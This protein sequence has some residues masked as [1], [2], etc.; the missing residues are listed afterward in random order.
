MHLLT[1]SVC[2]RCR[3]SVFSTLPQE[4]WLQQVPRRHHS[5]SSGLPNFDDIFARLESSSRDGERRDSQPRSHDQRR[6][7]PLP[8]K[9]NPHSRSPFLRPT[10]GELPFS[11]PRNRQGRSSDG[12]TPRSPPPNRRIYQ[13]P[14]IDPRNAIEF[15]Q[16]DVQRW[17]S[18]P[19]VR[20]R[21]QDFG[22]PKHNIPALLT[23]FRKAVQS[24]Q[25][26]TPATVE[27]YHIDRF[28]QATPQTIA[29]QIDVI[30]N[31]VFYQWAADPQNEARLTGL[32][33][34]P[35]VVEGIQRLAQAADRSHPAEEYP[36]ARRMHRKV[37][38]HVGPTNSGKTHH[39][40]RALAASK[41]GVYAGPLRLLAHEI[42]E[43]LNLGEIIPLGVEE[44]PITPHT[45]KS[46]APRGNPLYAQ[47]CNMVT[48]EE[49][50]IV[51]QDAP[52]LSC[53]VE[54]LMLGK[55]YD[56]AVV[57]E[58][59]MIADDQRGYAWTS[60]VLG[61]C[62]EEVHLCG[63]ET[64]VPIVEALL[65]D[66]GDEL[67]VNRYERLT[68]LL[69]EKQSLAGDL[70]NVKPGDCI[71]TFSRSNIFGIKRQV[72]EKTG[73]RCAVVYGKLPPEIR[74]EQAA[75]FNDPNSGYDVLIGSDAIGMGLNLK[76]RR[77]IF[78]TVRK[79]DGGLDVP[80][81]VSQ[82][83]QIAGRAG[84][85][86]LNGSSDPAGYVTTLYPNDLSF[87]KATIAS[88]VSPLRQALL[89]YN[90]NTVTRIAGALPPESSL[91][92]IHQ[93][94][95]YASTL[96]P[97]YKYSDCRHQGS[98]NGIIAGIEEICKFVDQKGG[99]LPM[100]DRLQLLNAPVA[101]RVPTAIQVISDF[102]LQ[103]NRKVHVSLMSGLGK[104]TLLNKLEFIEDKMKIEKAAVHD[105]VKS[106]T[107]SRKMK[108][109]LS[110]VTSTDLWELEVLHGLIV[111]YLWMSF[112]NPVAYSDYEVVTS[113][114]ERTE[115]ALEWSLK[116][117]GYKGLK[118]EVGKNQQKMELMP[119]MGMEEEE[120]RIG[121]TN[122]TVA[123]RK[124]SIEYVSGRSKG[125]W[126]A[127]SPALLNRDQVDVESKR[128]VASAGLGGS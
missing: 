27:K 88:Q 103:Y 65:K 4:L 117:I 125:M 16:S 48:G 20:Q 56:V 122:R 22:I 61:L 32:V 66:T 124:G 99:N 8:S 108:A 26:S 101:W 113:L 96:D 53:T 44:K 43:R 21:L 111:F 87:V 23:A 73:M 126:S 106:N 80:L 46:I 59:Q 85:Y 35:S 6:R 92:T 98:K 67:I 89:G 3:Y 15:F 68:P 5:S 57:D 40:L 114:K 52:L 97:A 1:R 95:T 18:L 17:A 72:E 7:S 36:K 77:I 64:A 112:R 109:V 116:E 29:S 79:F 69:V 128:R 63:E 47:Q 100:R 70:S 38:M 54:M 105:D 58:I 110:Q 30:Y 91:Q 74:S 76:I 50:K 24:G 90:T 25:L 75:L 11:S 119:M 123:K 83:K 28:A 120:A 104:T 94:H 107:R 82:V 2:T 62:A 78:E 12:F 86:G 49:Q 13:A 121:S 39:A 9:T 115:V 81:S 37:I 41:S 71:V 127:N 102:V 60:A 93:A 42:W 33:R 45:S 55:M 84:R 51:S 10:Q 118:K 31:T 34:D 19:R 14:K